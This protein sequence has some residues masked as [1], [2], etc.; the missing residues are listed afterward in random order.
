[1]LT[2][3]NSST[4]GDHT[5]MA[6]EKL[7]LLEQETIILFNRAEKEATIYTHEPSL[8]KK[9]T[10]L[11]EAAP[12]VYTKKSDNGAGGITYTLPKKLISIRTAREKKVLT[13]EQKKTLREQFA[14]NIAS[15]VV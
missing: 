4:K 15:K 2:V 7:S 13:E 8:I 1:M 9:L 6:T 14:K 5:F 11:C 10:E 12:K 3:P